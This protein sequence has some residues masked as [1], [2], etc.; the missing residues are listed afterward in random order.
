MHQIRFSQ[1]LH[2]RSCWGSSPDFQLYLKGLTSKGRKGYR[3]GSR[4]EEERER[5][6]KG[7]EER[8]P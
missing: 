1:G 7:R 2:P 5:R 4:R 6:G 8:D 3:I